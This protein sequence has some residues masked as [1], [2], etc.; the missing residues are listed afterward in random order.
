MNRLSSYDYFGYLAGGVLFLI[1]LK[2]FY[3]P[4]LYP[5]L[6]KFD[7]ATGV[8]WIGVAYITGHVLASGASWLLDQMI[9]D[10][11]LGRPSK[12]L[13]EKEVER[14]RFNPFRRYLT[15]LPP[16]IQDR[17]KAAAKLNNAEDFFEAAFAH[18]YEDEKK[19]AR[20]DTFLTLYQFCRHVS[21]TCFIIFLMSLV[22]IVLCVG[23]QNEQNWIYTMA[24]LIVCV[25]MFIR[26]LYFYRHY[27]RV[28]FTAAYLDPDFKSS[29]KDGRA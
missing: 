17:I 27:N 25:I 15:P 9:L 19:A 28:L 11:Y 13:F 20:Q 1:A 10:K 23:V 18:V 14:S 26:Y 21:F 16:K 4:E 8:I 7:V 24:S 6:N 29:V 22:N 5:A 3:M 12:L 2:H